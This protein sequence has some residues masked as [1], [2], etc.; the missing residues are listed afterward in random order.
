MKL[1]IRNKLL[2]SFGIVITL[3]VIMGSSYFYLSQEIRE[4][5]SENDKL[6]EGLMFIKEKEID[7]LEWVA[8]LKNVFIFGKEFEGEL[9]HTK[10]SFGKWYYS[11]MESDDYQKLPREIKEILAKIEEAHSNLHHSASEIT[12]QYDVLSTATSDA[13]K[14]AIEI[15]KNKTSKYL[16]QLQGLFKEYQ[17]FLNKETTK[18]MLLVQQRK[19]SIDLTI[20]I[21]IISAIVIATVLALFTSKNITAPLAKA[22][23]FADQIAHKNLN[24]K[25]L[26]IKSK[27]EVG[28]LADSL[29]NMY[30]NLKEMIRELLEIVKSL[31]TYSEEL[32][33]SAQEGDATI[34]SNNQLIEQM[35]ASIQEIA[36]ST[37]EVTSFAEESSVKTEVGNKDIKKT[38]SSLQEISQEVRE[39]VKAISKL[40]NNSREI[41]Q[42][43]GLITNIAKQTNLLALNAAIEAARAGENGQ[44]FAVVAEEIRELAE[45]TSQATE[46][47]A[48][49]VKE[50]QDKSAIGLEAIKRVESK[51]EKGE[52]VAQ[53]A[54]E[55]FK[56]I[57]EASEETVV[58]LEQTAASTQT[59][60]ENSDDIVNISQ[61]VSNMSA[62]VTTSSENLAIMAQK[63]QS[64]IEKFE[65]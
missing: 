49:L 10:C 34:D 6:T 52:T 25:E 36:A 29:N 46:D 20:M 45:E 63:L 32:H 60:S 48:K 28:E 8:E 57:Q 22:V 12:D 2:I 4:I 65:V 19:K 37:E 7:H 11:F 59:L 39:T 51:V 21:L 30:N 3:M 27:D 35:S 16:T 41:A 1:K 5:T 54:G 33:A 38:V 62:E 53:K 23:E 24:L 58:H 44:G 15:Y 42:I 13:N 61:E 17:D 18:N 40:D 9:D 50:T 64:L 14:V 47:I 55:V 31:S 43:V 56:E 26:H